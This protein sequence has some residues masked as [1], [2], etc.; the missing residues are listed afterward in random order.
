MIFKVPSSPNHSL[1]LWFFFFLGPYLKGCFALGWCSDTQN[2]TVEYRAEINPKTQH[3]FWKGGKF[4]TLGGRPVRARCLP[5]EETEGS[6]HSKKVEISRFLFRRGIVVMQFLTTK[7]SGGKLCL[8]AA[9]T[10]KKQGW[11][12]D[13]EQLF[14]VLP[15]PIWRDWRISDKFFARCTCSRGTWS[16]ANLSIY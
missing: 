9:P 2:L 5:G 4:L 12:P 16:S 7:I 3:K 6:Q 14:L 15:W 11:P 13:M 1:S 8:W 10:N